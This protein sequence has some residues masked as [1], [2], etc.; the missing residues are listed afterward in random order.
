MERFEGLRMKSSSPGHRASMRNR[1]KQF[2]EQDLQPICL[3]VESTGEIPDEI[4][5]KMRK[6]GLFGLSIPEKYGGLGLSTLD[7]ILVYEELRVR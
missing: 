5:A 6:I 7:E 2:V 4:V 1:V 3:Q